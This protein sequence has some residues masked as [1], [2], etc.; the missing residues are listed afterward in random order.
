MTDAYYW[1]DT[2]ARSGIVPTTALLAG[3]DIDG[4]RIYVGRA[5][6]EGDWLP[7]KVIPEKQVAYVSYGGA[8]HPKDHYQVLCEQRFEWVPTF[9]GHV[10]PGA[11]EGG[12]TSDGESLYIGRVHH[13]NA[14]T[15]GKVHPS[16]G[17][18]YVPF[19]G[20]E[21]AHDSYET[22]VLIN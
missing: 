15:V 9:G 22:L 14:I 2:F 10:P 18:C 16:H 12:K 3:H 19:D 7:A 13:D 1:V 20:K 5:F 8:E 4:T 11:V 6:H 21:V 17:V